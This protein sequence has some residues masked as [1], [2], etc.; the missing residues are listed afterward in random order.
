MKIQKIKDNKN[1][2]TAAIVIVVILLALIAGT[3][4]AINQGFFNKSSN[5]GPTTNLNPASEEE[6]KEGENTK[7]SSVES[8]DTS[9]ESTKN[10]DSPSQPSTPSTLSVQT[11]A[12]AQN[13]TTYQLRYLIESVLNDATCTLTLKKGSQVVTKTSKTQALAQSS[14]CQGFDISTSEI[15]A[16]TWEATLV[17][18][19]QNVTGSTNSTIRVQ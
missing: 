15:G 8:E 17:V 10:T 14:T 18:T 1:K 4:Y 9:T 5:S 3:A 2:K 12:S 13:G 19:G 11:S 16:G 7:S 6:K